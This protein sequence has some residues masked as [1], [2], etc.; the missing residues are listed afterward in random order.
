MK[1][2]KIKEHYQREISNLDINKDNKNSKL[3]VEIYTNL[4]TRGLIKED[5]RFLD[6]SL[7]IIYETLSNYG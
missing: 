6:K 4:Y 3:S 5:P 7:K 1:Y 2:N